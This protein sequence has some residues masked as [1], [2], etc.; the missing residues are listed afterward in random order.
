VAYTDKTLTCVDC[1]TP[2]TFSARDQEFHASKGFANEPKRCANCRQARRVQ[3]GD[4]PAGAG[5]PAQRS[6]STPVYSGPRAQAQSR[7][8]GRDMNRSRGPRRDSDRGGRDDGAVMSGSRSFDGN[9][10]NE[11]PRSYT[12]SCMACGKETNVPADAGNRV[13][14][15]QECYSKM[16]AMA[17]S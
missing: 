2:F 9:G 13:I 10:N 4:S 5:G 3:R 8:G 15:C 11:A 17:S 12:A 6:G 14:F 16:T 1:Q 7:P